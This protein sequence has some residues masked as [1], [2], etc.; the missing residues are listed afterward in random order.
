MAERRSIGTPD[1][2]ERKNALKCYHA[3]PA[4]CL[5]SPSDH[6][7][8]QL[9][10]ETTATPSKQLTL[11]QRV[12]A[13]SVVT[14]V[15]A[16]IS[17]LAAMTAS[18]LVS[19]STHVAENLSALHNAV[20]SVMQGIGDIVLSEGS[21]SARALVNS[22]AAL[23]DQHFPEAVAYDSTLAKERESWGKAKSSIEKLL[24]LKKVGPDDDD[25]LIAYGSLQEQ[26]KA[27]NTTL[28]AAEAASTQEAT[29]QTR[30]AFL[31]IVACLVVITVISTIT[32]I[33]VVR[34]IRRRVGADPREV[35][36]VVRAI[37]AGDLQSHKKNQSV[38][39]GSILAEMHAMQ[40]TLSEMVSDIRQQSD[41][42]ASVASQIG[43]VSGS[44][45]DRTTEAASQLEQSAGATA[46]LSE[47]ATQTAAM[48]QQASTMAQSASVLASQGGQVVGGVV[49]T[50]Q[51][52][53]QSSQ[54]ISDI[55]SVIDGIA[56]QTNILALNA[57]VEAAR[58]GEQGRGFAVVA[59]EVRALAQ[60]SAE[61]AREI[62]TL[63]VHS[64]SSVEAGRAQ[65]E[66]AG[67]T[68]NDIVEG[69]AGVT[70]LISQISEAA[71]GQRD[72]LS[73]ITQNIHAVDVITK[74]NVH[75]VDDSAAAT[76]RLQEQASRLVAAVSRFKT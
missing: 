45:H 67:Q 14:V 43:A 52:I 68:M 76:L 39:D 9:M 3:P 30:Q 75:V 57:A 66:R 58:A 60:R 44:L 56:F 33:L 69:V 21:K 48:A 24:A 73:A 36:H 54:K 20:T 55:I 2:V 18:Q 70:G 42:L 13:L 49:E 47:K 10:R 74:Q 32:G 28:T 4:V 34:A 71:T 12:T 35:V 15:I 31:L 64:V 7:K 23:V 1:W 61:A 22:S 6:P 59:S 65:V 19:R 50:M 8:I 5:A 51:A 62:K 37:V 26:L 38:A 63:I 27:I 17:T 11:I 53:N 29:E 72:A 40:S 16:I 46:E 41:E 25:T